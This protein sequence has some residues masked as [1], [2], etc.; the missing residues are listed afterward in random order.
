VETQMHFLG[1]PVVPYFSIGLGT[2]RISRSM[3]STWAWALSPLL[4]LGRQPGLG[5]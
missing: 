4:W 1:I 3:P 2:S 5:P